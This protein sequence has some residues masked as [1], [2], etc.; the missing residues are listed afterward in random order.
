MSIKGK[1]ILFTGSL[2]KNRREMIKEAREKGAI[3]R[4]GIMRQLDFIV[5][6]WS[7]EEQEKSSKIK[8]ARQLGI[9][10]IDEKEYRQRMTSI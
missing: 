8:K 3:V 9:E 1:T 7:N 5:S 4:S 10:I 6:G 2:S